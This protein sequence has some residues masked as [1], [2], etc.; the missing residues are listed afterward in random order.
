MKL[1]PT[2]FLVPG[3]TLEEDV[4]TKDNQVLAGRATILTDKLISKLVFDT[5]FLEIL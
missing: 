4:V 3:M 1:I 5:S 2:E